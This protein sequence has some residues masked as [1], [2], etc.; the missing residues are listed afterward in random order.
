MQ[1]QLHEQKAFIS[2][3]RE[4]GN[5][6]TGEEYHQRLGIW[7]TNKRL[8]QEHNRAN[9]GFTV[10]LNKLA[11]LSPAEYRSM[12]GFHMSKTQV[13][14]VK[15]NGV[16]NNS[17]DWRQKGVVNP[18]KDQ[19]QCGSCWAFSAI[20]AQESQYAITFGQLQSLSEQNLVN[21]VD[22]CSGCEGGMMDMAYDYVIKHQNGKFMLED[23]YPY[24]ATQESCK[25]DIKKGVSNINSYLFCEE[26]SE[27]DLA[28]KVSTLGPASIAIDASP[29]SFQFYSSGIY[30]EPSCSSSLLDHGVGCVG[31]GTENNANYWIVRNSWGA[32]WGEKGYIRM[33]KD[34]GNQCGEATFAL[35]PVD[36]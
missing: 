11:H 5:M 28:I 30:D 21:C 6:F 10:A 18:V 35:F 7:L 31:F 20:Q 23:D 3:M 14:A 13:K 36:R 33:I 2:W 24:S 29:W 19:A 32:S 27:T 26:G 8:V 22:S 17:C 4:T 12:L 25:F 9:A 16:P 34:K 15:S 1:A